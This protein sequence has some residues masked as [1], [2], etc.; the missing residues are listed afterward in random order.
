M[1]SVLRHLLGVPIFLA[2]GC[3]ILAPAVLADQP[4]VEH[5]SAV[6]AVGHSVTVAPG[7]QLD[8]VVVVDGDALIEGTVNSVTVVN[9]TATLRAAQI[10]TLV[11]VDGRADLGTGTTITGDLVQF[12]STVQRADGVVMGGTVRDAAATLAGLALFLGFAA[13]LIW[14]GI[15]LTTLVAGFA[16]AAFGAR[17]TR[18]A[19]AIISREP[20]KAFFAGLGMLIGVPIVA[21]LLM[22]SIVGAPLGVS[23][24]LFVLPTIAFVGY[25]V[26][27]I[28]MGEWLL[29]RSGRAPSERP[30][31]A[32]LVGLVVGAIL[33]FVPLITALISFFGVGAVTIA[34]WRTLVGRGGAVQPQ[35]FQTHASGTAA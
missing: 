4:L 35:S 28:W 23:V 3:L 11:I 1:K 26:A 9:G 20:V 14:F 10:E 19:E 29:A 27:A 15:V 5:G 18:A 16:L 6:V 31:L 32:A 22:V 34:G 7:E 25:L 17:Q 8:A 21:V 33:G 13:L 30:Y 24:L 2:V 12:S